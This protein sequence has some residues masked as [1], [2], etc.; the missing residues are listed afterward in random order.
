[1]VSHYLKGPI[2]RSHAFAGAPSPRAQ[3]GGS[4]DK[5]SY[6]LKSST[7]FRSK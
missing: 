2:I 1:M 7:I 6:L 4:I 3:G 5:G